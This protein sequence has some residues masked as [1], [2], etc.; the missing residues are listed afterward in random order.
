MKKNTDNHA[1]VALLRGINVG[2]NKKVPMADLKKIMEKA[3]YKNVRTLLATGNV[4][5]EAGKTSIDDLTKKIAALLEKSFGFPIPVIM[6]EQADIEKM[7][8]A[9]PFKKIKVTPDTRLYVTFLPGKPKSKLSIPYAAPDG[10]VEII[11]VADN[12]VF[13]VLDL[14]KAGTVDGMAIIEKEF[15]KDVTT[16]NW[17]TVVKIGKA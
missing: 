6:R 12:A 14:S 4:I 2:G 11:S 17:N 8:K 5:F 7:I 10:S 9:D 3:G 16:R 13:T 1:Y 15:G